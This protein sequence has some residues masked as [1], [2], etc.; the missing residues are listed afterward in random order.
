LNAKKTKD[1]FILCFVSDQCFSASHSQQRR[2]DAVCL[3]H[4]KKKK[5]ER[6]KVQKQKNASVN[7]YLVDDEE[8]L[9]FWLL[10]GSA[11]EPS[12]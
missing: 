3:T 7:T 5:R 12:R 10:E 8:E 1:E 11:S 6:K 2:A 9:K 4:K